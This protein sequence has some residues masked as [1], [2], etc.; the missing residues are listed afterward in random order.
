MS[1]ARGRNYY[2]IVRPLACCCGLC[3]VIAYVRALRLLNVSCPQTAPGAAG[4]YCRRRW[5]L[6]RAARATP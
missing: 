3:A 4:C 2:F 5:T 6:P 1:Y